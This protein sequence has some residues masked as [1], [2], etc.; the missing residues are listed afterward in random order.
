[1][2]KI[3][4]NEGYYL[5]LMDRLYIQICSIEDHL[6]GHPLTKK[7]K[8]VKKLIDKAGM[9]LAEAYQIVGEESYLR[10]EKNETK[11][12]LFRRHKKPKD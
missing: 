6:V 5:E 1:M 4:I 7:I 2:K 3:K 9:S 10:K 11:K 8:K 12:T